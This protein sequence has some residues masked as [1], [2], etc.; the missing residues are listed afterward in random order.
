MTSSADFE[1]AGVFADRGISRTTENRSAFLRM[2]GS[3]RQG[4]I[5][6][7]LTKSISRFARNTAVM[8]EV[9]RELKGLGV[10]VRF[11]K[12]NINTLSGDGE[13]MLTVLSNTEYCSRNQ[14]E[15]I[16]QIT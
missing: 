6:V 2:L 13:L 10:E 1:Y 11:E 5:D 9:V 14:N 7:I 4:K 15:M 16:T 8:L 3:A 12:E